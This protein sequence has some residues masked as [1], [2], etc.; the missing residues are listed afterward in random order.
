MNGEAQGQDAF[1][2]LRLRR[3][4]PGPTTAAHPT[5]RATPIPMAIWPN[6]TPLLSATGSASSVFP[7]GAGVGE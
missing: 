1:R 7:W 2:A 6:G 5:R 4:S 3:Y